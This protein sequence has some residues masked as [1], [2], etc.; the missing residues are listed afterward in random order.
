MDP[1]GSDRADH[2]RGDHLN[3]K[4]ADF[5]KEG[6]RLKIALG[7]SPK[8]GESIDVAVKYSLTDP[9]RGIYFTGPTRTI[10]RNDHQ[11]WTQGQD[12]DSRYWF[13]TFDYPN[14]KA[15][16]EIIARVPKGFTAVSNGAL[17]SKKD[18]D[19]KTQFHYKIGVL[20]CDLSDHARCR[21][22]LPNGRIKGPRIFRFSILSNQDGK[23][24][25]NAPSATLRR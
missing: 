16:S 4:V 2:S 17:L 11:V 21:V 12:E 9:R 8:P 24:T 7:S 25:E 20:P 22:S 15:T 18:I 13:P 3:G 1:S 10:R 6:H 23:R 5:V 19:G 14:Q